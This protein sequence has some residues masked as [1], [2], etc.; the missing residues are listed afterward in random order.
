MY[1]RNVIADPICPICLREDETLGLLLWYCPTT[2]NAWIFG[3]KSIQKASN[4]AIEF[5]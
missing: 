4:I 1:K 3:N 2:T 5:G